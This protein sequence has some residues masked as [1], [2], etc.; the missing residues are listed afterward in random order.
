[1]NK[2]NTIL[3]KLYRFEELSTAVL[4]EMLR[5]RAEVFVVEQNCPYQ[6]LD[7][8][9]DQCFHLLGWSTNGDLA[10]Y[11]RIFPVG[12]GADESDKEPHGGMGRVLVAEKYRG[13]G[14]ELISKALEM[15]DEVVGKSYPCVIHAQAHLKHFYES[16]GFI[17]TSDIYLLD[18]IDHMEMR[19]E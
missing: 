6:D 7:G 13:I 4:Y 19:R 8:L 17:Q 18:G 16:H 11:A 14:H 5:L 3:W 12:V 10:A 15:Y 9:D 1:M 2:Q